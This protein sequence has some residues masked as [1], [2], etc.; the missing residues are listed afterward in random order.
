MIAIDTE[1]HKCRVTWE[2]AWKFTELKICAVDPDSP[3]GVEVATFHKGWSDRG[4]LDTSHLTPGKRY[5]F[6][7]EA[8]LE[9]ST[10]RLP[11]SEIRGDPF[12][13]VPFRAG[14]TY[15]IQQLRSGWLRVGLCVTGELPDGCL[16]ISRSGRKFHLPRSL[17][18]GIDEFFLFRCE[19]A[20][21]NLGCSVEISDGIRVDSGKTRAQ[22]TLS[23]RL[24]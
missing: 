1:N 4:S 3:E 6:A 8:V 20:E 18:P 19:S 23:R 24:G 22:K 2:P 17:V 15:W 12:I 7:A 9:D 21:F 5:G 11:E 10:S 14:V 16:W 13:K